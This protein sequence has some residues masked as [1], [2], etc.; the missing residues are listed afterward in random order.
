M[1]NALGMLIA[2]SDLKDIGIHTEMM[3]D[4]YLALY[5]AGKVTNRKK[6]IDRGKGV[7]S[8]GAGSQELYRLLDRNMSFLPHGICQ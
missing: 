8:V 2:Q 5:Q 1:P 4:G 3:G 6:E 7:F